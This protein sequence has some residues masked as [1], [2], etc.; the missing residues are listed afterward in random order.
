MHSE[1][2]RCK[3]IVAHILTTRL[4]RVAHEFTL[5]IVVDGFAPDGCQY[6]AEDDE[7]SEPDFAH[8]GGV[9]GNLIQK[10]CEEAPAHFAS[11]CG[12]SLSNL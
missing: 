6:D 12:G 11:G 2:E 5:F 9:V 3:S 10:T 7:E 4:I 1:A 8:K